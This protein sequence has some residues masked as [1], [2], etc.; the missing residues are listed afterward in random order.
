MDDGGRVSNGVISSLEEGGYLE[1]EWYNPHTFQ[2]I[3]DKAIRLG[4]PTPRTTPMMKRRY[5]LGTTVVFT[6]LRS[7]I[8][9]GE[10]VDGK[11]LVICEVVP[12]RLVPTSVADAST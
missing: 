7:Q 8:H 1:R 2:R 4:S 11:V 3:S 9:E 6:E 5:P 10:G 12:I